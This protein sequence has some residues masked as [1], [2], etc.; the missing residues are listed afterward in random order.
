MIAI[1]P[2]RLSVDAN[3]LVSCHVA[4]DSTQRDRTTLLD[5]LHPATNG[6]NGQPAGL[7]HVKKRI[8]GS[9]PFWR[10]ATESGKVVAPR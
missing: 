3:Y 4:L 2:S 6:K 7:G 8:F 10:V 5:H 1:D 9:I